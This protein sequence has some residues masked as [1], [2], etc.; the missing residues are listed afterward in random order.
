[1]SSNNRNL[2]HLGTRINP[3]TRSG[4][5][6]NGTGIPR[7]DFDVGESYAGL[8]P[9]GNDTSSELYFWFFPSTNPV[10]QENK[11]ILIYLT[12]GP[13]CSS[14]GELLQQNGPLS[15]PPGTLE[16]IENKWS[17]HR[18]TNV[19]WI[20]QPVG[21]GFSQG[22]PTATSE[23]DVA[24]QFLG[25]WQNFVDR[26][27][28]QGYTVYVTGS[29]YGGM[30]APFIS[31]AMLDQNDKEYFNVS[32]MAVWDGLYSKIPLTEDI[33]VATFVNKWQTALPFN[34]TFMAGI[35]AIDEQC[36]YTAY[37]GE[38]LVFPPA[39]P[40]PSILPGEDPLTGLA[41]PECAL[42]IAVFLAA[43]ELNPCLNAF[44]I[45]SHCPILFGKQP[46]PPL[47]PILPTNNH[48][49]HLSRPNRLLRRHIHAPPF[50]PNPLLQP[51][52]RQGRPQRAPQR[53]LDLLRE[54]GRQPRLR[55]Q[56][57]RRVPR[58]GPGQPAR[59]AGRHRA[60]GQRHPGARVARLSR[61]ARGDAADHSEPDVGGG[62]GVPG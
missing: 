2:T 19:V 41:K 18:L 40:Q 7:V 3:L 5:A 27:A 31:S 47:V 39:G 10:A 43:K 59:P 16:P 21:T 8:L 17:W 32:G 33:P 51:P 48:L 58:L 20:D 57:R 61:A 60:H 30:Y 25:W 29:S 36:G 44:D 23:E 15:W 14:I 56:Q 12:G 4:F 50:L 35:K 62:D 38:F 52:G 28:L 26:F 13:G 53:D 34:D 42:Y 46:P 24:Q 11:E 45:T 49:T 22:V 37:L 54:P 6:V 55:Q 9:I 1:M